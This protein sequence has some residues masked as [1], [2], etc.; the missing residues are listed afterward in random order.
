MTEVEGRDVGDGME[1][2]GGRVMEV[3]GRDGGE[4]MG[5]DGGGRG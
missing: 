4:G 5:W 2:V 1:E 3:E